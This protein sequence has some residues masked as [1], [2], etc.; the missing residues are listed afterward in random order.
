MQSLSE[1]VHDSTAATLGDVC[2]SELVLH[3]HSTM[4]VVRW[5]AS[6]AV[7]VQYFVFAA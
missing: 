4:V 2:R 1:M 7:T 5:T 3:L 6:V